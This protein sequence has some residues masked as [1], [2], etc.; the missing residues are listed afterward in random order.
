MTHRTATG[1]RKSGWGG[2]R[3]R[4]G[5][6]PGR[7]RICESKQA[8][9]PDTPRVD[10]RPVLLVVGFCNDGGCHVVCDTV[11]ANV[12]C[13]N[14]MLLPAHGKRRGHTHTHE[15]YTATNG[16]SI[17]TRGSA[18]IYQT[19]PRVNVPAFVRLVC[20]SIQRPDPDPRFEIILSPD[21]PT[22]P[23]ACHLP[24]SPLT[25]RH[26][27]VRAPTPSISSSSPS[28]MPAPRAT[29]D[30]LRQMSATSPRSSIG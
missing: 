11:T 25:H 14:Q 18:I 19:P 1:R 20:V 7:G 23:P 4:G 6:W 9:F 24:L 29:C 12:T 17:H 13:R 8:S 26:F 15:I 21:H 28:F 3:R 2:G 30:A 22:H 16:T 27:P 10:V 5:L